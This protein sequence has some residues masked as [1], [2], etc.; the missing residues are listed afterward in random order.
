[1]NLESRQKIGEATKQRE[2]LLAS[3]MAMLAK[4]LGVEITPERV[5]LYQQPLGRLTEDQI[6]MAF[7]RALAEYKPYGGSFP[8]PA[9][10]LDYSRVNE[11]PKII[12]DAPEILRR[13]PKPPDWRP[14][15]ET[16]QRMASSALLEAW[17]I[18]EERERQQETRDI[19]AG[20]GPWDKDN[21]R[22]V[23][24]VRRMEA[25]SRL[26]RGV[27]LVPA[28]VRYGSMFASI[29]RASRE[30]GDEE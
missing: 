17:D 12:D 26:S 25:H 5:I 16:K 11:P 15:P 13:G 24:Y 7:R 19:L 29:V 10:L 8:S 6:R 18:V 27:K 4:G 23:D 20:D 14:A 21:E 3:C 9:E 30:P 2:K 22:Y 1:M 28:R